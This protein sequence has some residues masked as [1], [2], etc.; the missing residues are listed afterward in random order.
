MLFIFHFS[1]LS[2]LNLVLIPSAK[3]NGHRDTSTGFAKYLAWFFCI[4]LTT[5]LTCPEANGA[6]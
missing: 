2:S 6:V 4:P 3:L 1:S 5:C